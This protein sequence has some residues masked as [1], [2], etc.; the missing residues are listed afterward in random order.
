[1]ACCQVPAVCLKI[2]KTLII[3]AR[4]EVPKQ[5]SSLKLFRLLRFARN[6]TSCFF[7]QRTV[8]L[9]A[10]AQINNNVSCEGGFKTSPYEYVL[11][12]T[13]YDI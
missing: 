9:G 10:V 6:D 8:F 7:L 4:H 3:A 12:S 2:A 1:M 13:I 5:S 11:I